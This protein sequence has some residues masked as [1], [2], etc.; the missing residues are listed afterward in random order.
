MG[1]RQDAQALPDPP[2]ERFGG[3]RVVARPPGGV[4]KLGAL[5]VGDGEPVEDD[6]GCA[7]GRGRA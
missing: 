3:A 4:A 2:G 6:G 5:R 7:F 1:S